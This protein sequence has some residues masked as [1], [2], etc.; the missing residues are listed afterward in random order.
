MLMSFTNM[1]STTG[2]ASSVGDLFQCWMT[3][4]YQTIGR[5]KDHPTLLHSPLCSGIPML[6]KINAHGGRGAKSDG[7]TLWSVCGERLSTED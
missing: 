7:G 6:R 2:F 3:K 4:L 1:F 5:D